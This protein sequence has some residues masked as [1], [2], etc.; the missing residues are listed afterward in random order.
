MNPATVPF[1]TE[2]AVVCASAVMQRAEGQGVPT[3]DDGGKIGFRVEVAA[4]DS[5]SHPVGEAGRAAGLRAGI[6]V[7]VGEIH[8]P[9]AVW[10]LNG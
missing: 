5:P 4:V 7:G 1:V 9:K 3:A 10:P 8:V 6:I 2:E